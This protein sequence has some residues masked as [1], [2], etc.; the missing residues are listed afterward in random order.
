M[1]SL[2]ASTLLAAAGGSGATEIL[3]REEFDTLDGWEPFYF[4]GI[5]RH[6]EYSVADLG[7]GSVLVAKSKASASAL[8][9]RM[10]FSVADYPHLRWRWRVD[11]LY[12]GGDYRRKDGDDYPL[13]VYV[14]F[15]YDP[16]RADL[17]TRLKYR[18]AK[19]LYGTYPP[20]SS[21]N[22]IWANRAE[23]RESVANPFTERAMM[24]PI[25]SGPEKLGR[26]QEESVNILA[27]YLRL[28]GEP[29]PPLASLAIM[30]DS[31]N[32]GEAAV[33]FVDFI[34]ISGPGDG[35]ATE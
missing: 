15:A 30:N 1:T 19:T 28:F 32:T 11:K 12:A 23:E 27:D 17:A 31:D 35:K 13:R 9:G 20:H 14:I 21:I 10:R 7:E 25:Q 5:D 22:Y 29:P 26:W 6:S 24:V 2:L 18:L 16:D 3:L 34:E 8:I 33:S 4:R